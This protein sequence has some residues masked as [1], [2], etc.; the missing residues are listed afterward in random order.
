MTV[1]DEDQQTLMNEVVTRANMAQLRHEV[2]R[3]AHRAGLDSRRS[4]GFTV[5]VNEA[6][7]NAIRHAG[8]RGKVAVIQDDESRLIAEVSD[9]GPGMPCSVR[10][11]LPPPEAIGGRGMWL[12]EEL[13]DH[14]EVRSDRGGT[15]VHLEMDLHPEAAE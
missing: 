6:V 2:L 4:E 3:L 13:A 14:V 8:G 12:A 10:I 15:T 5:A 7:T 1:E 9:A 11:T